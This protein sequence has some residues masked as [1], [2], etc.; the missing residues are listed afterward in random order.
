MKNGSKGEVFGP[1][2]AAL[3]LSRV[4]LRYFRMGLDVTS[5]SKDAL[6][7]R[8]VGHPNVGW[9]FSAEGWF[10]LAVG[11]WV[12]DNAELN[13][14]SAQ[15]RALLT[16]GDAVVFQSE[17]TSLYGFG[18]RPVMGTG[19]PMC[20]IDAIVQ[21]VKLSPI[22]SDY[23]KL[24]T[25]DSS[26]EREELARLLGIEM[27]QVMSI[28]EKLKRDGVLVGY[29]ERINYAGAYGKVFV[30][31]A[32]RKGDR[33]VETL[34]ERLWRD[35][36]CIYFSRANSK[37]DIE[38][39]VIL[40]DRSG[41]DDY[42]GDFSDYQ[43]AFLTENLY[44]NL[45]P[46]SKTANFKEIQNALSA[47]QGEIVDFRNSKLWYLNYRG[48]EA[49]LDIYE[50][51]EYFEV[52]EKGELDLFRELTELLR[53]ECPG[54]LFNV[55]DLGSG[56][57]IKGRI[58][59]ERI[60]EELVK[61]YY[62]VDIQPIELE[63]A[64]RAHVDGKYAKHP[65]I[66]D[67]ENLSARFP[68]RLLP[69]ERQVVAFFGGTY[70]NFPSAEINAY[71]KPIVD[72]ST[73][74]LVTMPIVAESRTEQEIMDSYANALIE[75][76]AFGPLV[77]MGFSRD[78]FEDNPQYSGLKIHIAIEDHRNVISLILGR[79]VAVFGKTFPKGTVFKMTSSWKPTLEEF[80]EA[81]E[82]DFVV[83]EM[84]H[85]DDMA[86]AVIRAVRS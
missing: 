77:Q 51:K 13:D 11:L 78:D 56:N 19:E 20:I 79:E 41:L 66:L 84:L 83:E 33:A 29:Q 65:T 70:G 31:S 21:P 15:I 1:P 35:E 34:T 59:I 4:G 12:T 50:N 16:P 64:L 49:Y 58:F 14:V 6:V 17:L 55:I 74:L 67:I 8:L 18:N 45:Y 23:V 24:V 80:R 47:E 48:A 10:N 43:V 27:T 2:Y 54:S 53:H 30:D 22:E 38:F 44:T 32:S 86:I 63:A 69:N 82:E 3:N 71:L 60:G 46:L 62:P 7:K 25:M 57:G 28:E 5:S 68:L 36:A 73:T 9:I 61:A 52:M 72:D 37:Y 75:E 81:I 76:F 85:N 40:A 26:V 39:E 42:L